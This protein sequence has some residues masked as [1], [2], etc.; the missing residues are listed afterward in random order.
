MKRV[1]EVHLKF[2]RNMTNT[3]VI[4]SN[5]TAYKPLPPHHPNSLNPPNYVDFSGLR[6]DKAQKAM[7]SKKTEF[8]NSGWEVIDKR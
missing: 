4:L 8:I 7:D 6:E 2:E 5:Y 1:S 3:I